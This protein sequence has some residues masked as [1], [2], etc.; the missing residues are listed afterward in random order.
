MPGDYDP[1]FLLDATLGVKVQRNVEI[2]GSI[3]N[4]LNRRYFLFFL[5]PSRAVTAGLRITL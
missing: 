5:A 4:I 2:Y 1:F 3:E